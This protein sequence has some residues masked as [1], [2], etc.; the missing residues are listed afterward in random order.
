[1]ASEQAQQQ[2]QQ[3]QYD[4]VL[5]GLAARHGGIEPLLRTFFSFL[6][7]KT[8]RLGAGLP[9]VVV[10]DRLDCLDGSIDRRIRDCLAL[11]LCVCVS[12]WV[13]W[14]DGQAAAA[15]GID[16]S[17]R[18]TFPTNWPP[19]LYIN[20]PSPSYQDFYV[21]FPPGTPDARMGFAEGQ[22]ERLVR[23]CVCCVNVG[24]YVCGGV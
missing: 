21:S 4:E 8:A 3:S 11:I 18:P 17:T 24:V 9:C 5:L 19:A 7:R 22:A 10:L 1:M 13:G 2:A 14:I 6:H 16:R 15:A 20:P 12:V 23:V